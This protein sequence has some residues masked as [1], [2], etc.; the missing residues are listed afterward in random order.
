[1]KAIAGLKECSSGKIKHKDMEITNLRPHEIVETGITLVPERRR[2]FP[3]MTVL[4][5][6]EMGA[7]LVK[8]K[9]ELTKRFEYTFGKFPKLKHRLSQLASTLSGGEQQ[10][11]AIGRGL[12]AKP[13][14]L[15]LDEPSLGLA[16]IIVNEV[17]QTIKELSA[18][19]TILLV[20]QNVRASLNVCNRVFILSNGQIVH[21]DT[22]KNILEREDLFKL[23]VGLT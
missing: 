13:S 5:N 6:L 2:I 8:D 21:E 14:L 3:D 4:E 11:L 10:M 15:I 17:F 20:E 9:D 12:M 7:F 19:M 1:V 18:E 16:P 23:Y 22:A